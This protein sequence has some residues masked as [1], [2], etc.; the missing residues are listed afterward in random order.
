MNS[1]QA[2]WQGHK[3]FL[4]AGVTWSLHAN[5]VSAKCRYQEP[6]IFDASSSRLTPIIPSLAAQAFLALVNSDVFS[7]FLK[8][9]IKHNQDI[10][11]ND[12]RMMPIVIP[13]PKQH[14]WLNELGNLCIAT[15]RAEFSNNPLPNNIVAHS[16][17]IAEQLRSHAP[18]YLHPSAQDFLLATPRHCLSIL[19]SAVSW[20][21]EKLYGVEGLGPFEEF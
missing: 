16:R 12:M 9:F 19:E 18:H 3:F 15:K 17:R 14:S 4:K 2:R 1:P 20:E 8:K 13:N 21:A 7:F 6:C 5:H 10:E 11:I